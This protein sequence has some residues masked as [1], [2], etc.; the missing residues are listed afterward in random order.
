MSTNFSPT[1]Q[2]ENNQYIDIFNALTNG[3]QI[4][5]LVTDG[6]GNILSYNQRAGELFS[7]TAFNESLFE[8]FPNPGSFRVKEIF[9]HS[10]RTNQISREIANLNLR[11]GRVNRFE[12]SINPYINEFSDQLYFISFNL[13][14][15]P[16]IDDKKLNISISESD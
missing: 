12:V 6:E 16:E 3:I 2:T 8:I 10:L 7:L 4:P 1:M 13:L 5:T 9:E 14:Y 11:S 15:L